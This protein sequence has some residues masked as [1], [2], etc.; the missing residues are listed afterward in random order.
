MPNF[1]LN[2]QTIVQLLGNPNFYTAC[3]AYIFMRDQA[4]AAVQDFELA[5]LAKE[6]VNLSAADCPAGDCPEPVTDDRSIIKGVL[7]TF[8]R[9]TVEAH[10]ANP[11]H[12]LPL[13]K[14]IA[15]Q[16]KF[17]PSEIL[18]NYKRDGRMAKLSF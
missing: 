2:S 4:L 11:E 13:R 6:S 15:A 7:A 16:L 3:P 8:V 1:Q 14:F 17:T 18:L 12:L 9:T 5:V 10:Q